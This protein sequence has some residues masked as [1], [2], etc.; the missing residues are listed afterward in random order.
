MRANKT[1]PGN[2]PCHDRLVRFI[3]KELIIRKELKSR[4]AEK[5]NSLRLVG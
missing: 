1:A 2:L 3:R 4:K 5:K